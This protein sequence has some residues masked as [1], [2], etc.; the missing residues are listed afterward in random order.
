MHVLGETEQCARR[1]QFGIVSGID[2]DA[3][4]A[5]QHLP[6]EHRRAGRVCYATKHYLC[7]RFFEFHAAFRA[8]FWGIV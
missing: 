6:F 8:L 2:S 4:S 3:R 1:F 5:P 7:Y